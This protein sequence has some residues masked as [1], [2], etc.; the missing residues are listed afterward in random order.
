MGHDS[1]FVWVLDECLG[2][3]SRQVRRVPADCS[4]EHIA[5]YRGINLA[6]ARRKVLGSEFT[7]VKKEE[8][9]PC[10]RNVVRPLR[11]H[12]VTPFDEAGCHLEA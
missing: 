5:S 2:L 1:A 4:E 11:H 7:V 6:N 8:L 10:A 12:R 3:S 9:L